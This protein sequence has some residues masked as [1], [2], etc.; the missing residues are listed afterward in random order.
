LGGTF[1]PGTVVLQNAAGEVF[2]TFSGNGTA[3]VDLRYDTYSFVVASVT[4][5]AAS[6]KTGVYV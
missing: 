1:G 4:N 2:A 5:L 3:T 6:I